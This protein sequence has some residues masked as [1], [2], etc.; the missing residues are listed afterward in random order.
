MSA[1]T[2][3]L[4]VASSLADARELSGDLSA[5]AIDARAV[6]GGLYG[7]TC[8]ELETP[9]LIVTTSDLGDMSGAELCSMIKRDRAVRQIA[10]VLWARDDEERLAAEWSAIEGAGGKRHDVAFDRVIAGDRHSAVLELR[11][12]LQPESGSFPAIE[13]DDDAPAPT[14]KVVSGSLGVLSFVEL[15]QAFSQTGKTGCLELDLGGRRAVV[16]FDAGAIRH[17]AYGRS[18]GVDAFADVFYAS[19]RSNETNFRFE[20]WPSQRMAQEAHTIHKEPQQL[21]LAVA[22]EQ[23]ELDA[24]RQSGAQSKK[25]ALIDLLREK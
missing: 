20:P 7:L 21:L 14:S 12:W 23:D 4:I 5:E 24:E 25:S 16:L 19:E 10:V 13:I 17:A 15:V 22:V 1:I 11:R 3:V 18:L 8:L 2:K 6:V 9:D